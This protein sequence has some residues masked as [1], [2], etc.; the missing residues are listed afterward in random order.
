MIPVMASIRYV[1]I[2]SVKEIAIKRLSPR[3][4]IET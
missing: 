3:V 4:M 1:N 2:Q